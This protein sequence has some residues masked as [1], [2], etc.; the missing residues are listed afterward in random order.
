MALREMKEL[1]MVTLHGRYNNVP[2]LK[3]MRLEELHKFRSFRGDLKR[4]MMPSQVERRS[5]RATISVTVRWGPVS[6]TDRIPRSG[7][8]LLKYLRHLCRLRSMVAPA[9]TE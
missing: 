3:I 2:P 5:A 1:R 6:Q 8:S 4:P 9:Q 7:S